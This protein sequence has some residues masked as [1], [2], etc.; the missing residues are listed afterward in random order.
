MKF[1]KDVFLASAV[2]GEHNAKNVWF[3]VLGPNR[4][5][6]NTMIEKTG[7]NEFFLLQFG[8][9]KSFEK[10]FT[11]FDEAVSFASDNIHGIL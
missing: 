11:T 3:K 2:V 1:K 5:D 10:V 8:N 6:E 4:L 7:R 9:R